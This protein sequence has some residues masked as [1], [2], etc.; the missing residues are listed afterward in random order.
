LLAVPWIT[1]ALYSIAWLLV[2]FSV[3][4][5]S[6]AESFDLSRVAKAFLAGG[7]RERYLVPI[8][9]SADIVIALF[10]GHML[11]PKLTIGAL[12]LCCVAYLSLNILLVDVAVVT[13]DMVLSDP[14][15]ALRE[16]LVLSSGMSQD[17]VH[18]YLVSGN[19][20]AL[21]G[22]AF[23]CLFVPRFCSFLAPSDTYTFESAVGN[24]WS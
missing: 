19:A 14:A 21:F 15:L 3:A 23:A 4:Y 2:A 18:G 16:N 9:I 10:L 22:L 13:K 1:A 12:V 6:Y 11:R 24:V 7:D 8:L 20:L 17:G 5:S